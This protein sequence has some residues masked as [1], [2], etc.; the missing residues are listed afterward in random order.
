MWPEITAGRKTKSYEILE[1]A[2]ELYDGNSQKP[3]GETQE[4]ITILKEIEGL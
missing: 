1:I 2:W 4:K 3:A